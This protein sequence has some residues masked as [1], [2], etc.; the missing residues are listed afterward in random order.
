MSSLGNAEIKK[1]R[2]EDEEK[3]EQIKKFFEENRSTIIEETIS[4]FK[5]MDKKNGRLPYVVEHNL[6]TSLYFGCMRIE[7]KYMLERMIS[8]EIRKCITWPGPIPI[9]V[10]IKNVEKGSSLN[11]RTG[12]NHLIKIKVLFSIN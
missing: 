5:E 6:G 4:S 2:R 3:K 7:H 8:E 11:W 10:E 12:Y 1:L 9:H